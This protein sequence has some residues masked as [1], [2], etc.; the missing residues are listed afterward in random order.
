MSD[1][2]MSVI[3]VGKYR[4]KP[5]IDKTEWDSFFGENGFPLHSLEFVQRIVFE[6]GILSTVRPEA[7]KFLTGYYPW[8]STYDERLIIDSVRRKHYQ[9]LNAVFKK[10]LPLL[11]MEQKDFI[12]AKYIIGCDLKRMQDKDSEGNVFVNKSQL[13]NLLLLNYV[14]NSNSDYQPGFHEMMMLM[15]LILDQEYET[16]WIF[17]FFHQRTGYS[18]LLNCGVQKNLQMLRDIITILDPALSAYLDEKSIRTLDFLTPW[19]CLF[20]LRTFKYFDDVWRLWEVFLTMEPCKNFQ[21]LIAFC[22]LQRVKH[23]IMQESL[24]TT[25]I[26]Q[27]CNDMTDLDADELIFDACC[28]YSTIVA[29]AVELV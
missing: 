24:D 11:E 15:H 20:F 18:C 7:W 19:F 12:E 13:E 17:Q 8:R 25:A 22:I 21:V 10:I 6:R 26:L 2:A 3:D 16:F 4:T 23:Q 29:K 5:V 28:A 14:S 27:V 1:S 9:D